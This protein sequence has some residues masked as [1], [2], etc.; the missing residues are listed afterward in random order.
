[1]ATG[2]SQIPAPLKKVDFLVVH[3]SATPAKMN[4]DRNM[5]DRW[6][7]ERG[8]LGIGYHYVIK[9]DGTLEVGR[10]LD[11]IGAHVEGYNDRSLGICMA[12]GMDADNKKPENNFTPAQLATL[13]STLYTLLIEHPRA[14]ICGHNEL[15]PNKA[16]PSFDVPKWWHET[17][18]DPT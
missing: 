1:V 12:G 7:R 3:C 5:I 4:V 6:H 8:W 18:V 16:C 17:V 15:N 13:Q 9:R 14:R 10:P 2:A 11:Q